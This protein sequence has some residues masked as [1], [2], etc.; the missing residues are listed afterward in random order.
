MGGK[1]ASCTVDV[2]DR[3][4]WVEQGGDTY[5][6]GEDGQ[7]VTGYQEIEEKFYIFDEEGRLQKGTITY[8]GQ[9]FLAGEDGA[10]HVQAFV[11]GEDGVTYYGEDGAAVVGWFETAQD[12][13]NHPAGRY[14]QDDQTYL[15]AVGL[16][17]LGDTVYYFDASGRLHT[18]AGYVTVDGQ[19][20]YITADG[21]YSPPPVIT[22]VTVSYNSKTGENTVKVTAT[23]GAA[24]A[25][26]KGIQL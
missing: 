12:A 1:T 10:L 21:I 19:Q 4:T 5:Y 9:R 13:E 8:E 7:F 14:Y 15:L 22:D 26:E 20:Y 24:G 18:Q 11:E 16:V 3:N 6:I 23:F 25:A 2:A 17:P